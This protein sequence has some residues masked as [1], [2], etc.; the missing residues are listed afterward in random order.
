[1]RNPNSPSR[2]LVPKMARAA[3]H[4]NIALQVMM[5]LAK[6]VRTAD[7]RIMDLSTL[8]AHNRVHAELLR[9]ARIHIVDGECARIE[10]VP[11][12]SDIASRVRTTRETVARVMASSV[13]RS[14][15]G[16]VNW[17]R[18]SIDELV[19][20]LAGCYKQMFGSLRNE[21]SSLREKLF[22]IEPHRMM[23]KRVVELSSLSARVETSARETLAKKQLQLTAAENR[24]RGLNPRA[25]LERGYSITRSKDTGKVV[26]SDDDVKIGDV[27]STELLKGVIESKV[28]AKRKRKILE[29]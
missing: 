26:R 13:F 16:P 20:R 28:E 1:M 2:L 17:A 5:R 23:R 15:L 4:P 27:L 25:V 14:P 12:H 21:L 7:E 24:L 22:Q 11:V 8:A 3:E 18:Q 6:I 10:P 9:Q 19:M 29:N